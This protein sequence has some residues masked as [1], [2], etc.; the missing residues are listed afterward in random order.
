MEYALQTLTWGIVFKTVKTVFTDNLYDRLPANR[1]T[2]LEGSGAP[3]LRDTLL[4]VGARH[5]VNFAFYS[6]FL[7]REA[8][9]LVQ[10]SDSFFFFLGK[11]RMQDKANCSSLKNLFG[12]IGDHRQPQ[13]EKEAVQERTFTRWMNVFLQRCHPPLKVQDLFVDIQDGRILMA[14]LEELTGC[15]LLYRFRSSSHRIFRLN[16]ISKALAFLDDR[17]VKL[18]GIDASGVADGVP[19]VVLNL[20][21]NIILHFQAKEMTR[22]L[23][24]HL[25]LSLSSLPEST[26]AS[27][28]DLSLLPNDIGSYSYNTLPSKGRKT[29]KESK[30]H[31]KA[32]KTLLQWVQRCT[33]KF[34]VEVND[35]GRSW[36]NGLAFLA[37][38]KSM[39]PD[40]V[41]LR[42][43]LTRNPT[44]NL[45]EAFT[46][47]HRSLDVTPLLEPEDVTC[48]SPDEQS[49]ITYV[50]SFLGQCS[51]SDGGHMDY[52]IPEIPNFGSVES[53]SFGETHS[54]SAEARALLRG[55]EKSNEQLLWKR[56]SGVTSA[57]PHDPSRHTKDA[58]APELCSNRDVFSS[59][60]GQRVAEPSVYKKRGEFR[61]SFKPPS[62]L[63]ARIVSPEIRSWMEKGLDQ[64]NG[65]AG[66]SES[67]ISLSSEEGSYSLPVLD[68]D[69]ED[70]YSYILDLNKEVFQPYQQLSRVV[71]SRVV[72][73]EE[74][75]KDV[76]EEHQEMCETS[77][78]SESSPRKGSSVRKADFDA[79]SKVRDEAVAYR[80][81]GVSSSEE[82]NKRTA[83]EVQPRDESN[84]KKRPEEEIDFGEHMDDY[85]DYGDREKEEETENARALTRGDDE[86]EASAD[87]REQ[88]ES[89]ETSWWQN[90]V[91]TGKHLCVNSVPGNKKK[92]SEGGR[93]NFRSEKEQER[94]EEGASTEGRN[95]NQQRSEE[96]VEFGLTGK[97]N[98]TKHSVCKT[99]DLTSEDNGARSENVE[100]SQR[101]IDEC[102]T[103][104]KKI[105]DHRSGAASNSDRGADVDVHARGKSCSTAPTSLSGEGGFALRSAAAF[106][107]VT[108]L[109]LEVLTALW[110]LLYCCFILSQ[111]N[112]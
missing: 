26:Y 51:D 34:G 96:F 14:L 81:L 12:G 91:E 2:C 46:I 60:R 88:R 92:V 71:L 64:L 74:T 5:T 53:V 62:P 13:D 24:R 65:K 79:K 19:S 72:V 68:S 89:F 9:K 52:N 15:K 20:I 109:E 86:V 57:A 66:A 42:E 17:H 50:S 90:E 37:I 28:T 93:D 59:P 58:A 25:S 8:P 100:E 23:Q 112:L 83:F 32:I 82:T 107:D 99:R 110:I 6:S 4:R 43:S 54:D 78:G 70:A 80:R 38:I 40:L 47:A 69:E 103:T 98:F 61:S 94:K 106:C 55:L 30:Y 101:A 35:F 48:V 97:T 21:W 33:S 29:A 1:L 18:L 10:S 27:F 39:K 105:T 87:K 104:D 102:R 49:I 7:C 85:G 11:I 44:E 63:D 111:M 84:T 45:Q 73:E 31:G 41:D 16:N 67:H 77:I 22:G 75:V 3:H 36:R 56:W 95:K 108:P 76:D